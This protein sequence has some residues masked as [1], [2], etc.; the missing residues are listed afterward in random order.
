VALGKWCSALLGAATAAVSA[1][2]WGCL[3]PPLHGGLELW[4][5]VLLAAGS[6]GLLVGLAGALFMSRYRAQRGRLVSQIEKL[7][8]SAGEGPADAGVGL[9]LQPAA[10]AAARVVTAL[11]RRA[12]DLVGQKRELE[13]QLRIC[14]AER[15][16]AQ[17][18][19]NSIADGVIVTDAFNELALVNESAARM[20]QFEIEPSLRHPVDQVIHD[21]VLVKLIKDTR[22]GGDTSLRRHVEHQ[23]P[24]HGQ[25]ACLDVTLTC[26]A[27]GQR[28]AASESAGVVTILRD[29]T[30]E[31]E[32]EEMKSDFVSAVSHELRTPLSSIKAYM[33]MLVDGEADDDA[34]R[35][36]FY[37][38]VQGEANRLSR[39]IDNI[40]NISR[41]ESGMVKVQRENISLPAL[42]H[43][44]VDVMLPQARAK[45]MELLEVPTPLFFQVFADR[46]MIYQAIL[47]LVGNAIKYSNPG[48]KVTVAISVD[49]HAHQ[50]E[51]AV[52]D[53]GVGIPPDALPHLFEKFYRVSEHKKMAKGTGLGLNLVKQIIETVHSG[54]VRVASEAGK[55]STFTFSLPM[56]D[57]S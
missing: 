18:I 28:P 32:I 5:P 53:T 54:K 38:I 49:E 57:N 43:E 36:E 3:A 21:P 7:A 46:D 52:S 15:R 24:I 19:L 45:Q 20:L 4:T 26:V 27:G 12:E 40:L 17:A 2:V 41:I 25:K 42:V 33:E 30:R 11:R 10:D 55:G 51:V 50:V 35:Q 22:E 39:L 47:N 56:A 31:R 6:S 13:V 29:V 23:R 9:G 14:D 48:G 34:T 16:H 37:N 44:V 8:G 1:A